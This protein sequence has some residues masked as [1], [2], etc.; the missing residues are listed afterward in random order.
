MERLIKKLEE[1]NIE[2]KVCNKNTKHINIYFNGKV[3]ISYYGTT[4]TIY[5]PYVELREYKGEDM[6]VYLYNTIFNNKYITDVLIKQIEGQQEEND[7]LRRSVARKEQALLEKHGSC[8]DM[9]NIIGHLD[10]YLDK[11]KSKSILFKW[12]YENIINKLEELK[13]RFDYYKY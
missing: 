1:N 4:G 12:F 3:V 11:K 7:Y 2:Y 8:L 9:V 5:S 13:E 6:L 10:L